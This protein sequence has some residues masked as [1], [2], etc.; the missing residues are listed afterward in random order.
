LVLNPESLL[1]AER[2]APDEVLMLLRDLATTLL[3][4][5][6]DLLL[7]TPGDLLLYTPGDL[8]THGLRDLAGCIG[9]AKTRSSGPVGMSAASR[10]QV[11]GTNPEALLRRGASTGTVLRTPVR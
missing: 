10:H 11:V 3:Y 2:H 7:Y 8:P 9:A 6:G 1:A 4:T 5:P